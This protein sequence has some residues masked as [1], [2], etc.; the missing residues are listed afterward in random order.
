MNDD[1]D[2]LLANLKLYRMR[3]IVDRE[4]KK[5]TSKK[6]PSYSE[7]LATLLRE[8]Y[9]AKRERGI[10]SRIRQAKLPE[11]WTLESFPFDKQPSIPQATIYQL[12]ELDFIPQAQNLVLIGGTGVGK[13]GI[14]I[15]ILRKAIQNGYRGLFIKA[16]DLFDTM[17]KS[18]AD[19]ST[20]QF[21]NS[22]MKLDVLLIDEMGYLNLRPEQSNIF[23]KLMEERYHHKSTIITTNLEY[24]DWYQFLGNKQMVEAL[25][26]RLRHHCHTICIEGIDLR[27]PIPS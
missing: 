16:Q 2:Q 3:E 10:I 1:L 19:H 26:S 20:R 12:A 5:T 17:Y 21:L 25:L 14:G 18:L 8:E 15:S 24:D 7:F 13:T 27:G 6:P 4:L 23:F 11:E 9:L 22:L